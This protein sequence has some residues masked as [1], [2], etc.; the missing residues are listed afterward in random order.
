MHAHRGKASVASILSPGRR[1]KALVGGATAL[2]VVGALSLAAIVFAEPRFVAVCAA[3]TSEC[4]T[5]P[6]AADGSPSVEPTVAVLPLTTASGNRLRLVNENARG[7]TVLSIVG[8]FTGVS[9]DAEYD[10]YVAAPVDMDLTVTLNANE[11]KP[12]PLRGAPEQVRAVL[13]QLHGL[14]SAGDK[15]GARS[16]PS[17]EATT[18][19]SPEVD[20]GTA[21]PTADDAPAPSQEEEATTVVSVTTSR[22]D[23]STEELRDALT[24]HVQ[25]TPSPA[26]PS[27]APVASVVDTIVDDVAD[28]VANGSGNNGAAPAPAPS[29]TGTAAEE[30]PRP[31]PT[32]TSTAAP[33]PRPAVQ[34]P[35][36]EAEPAPAPA[37][38]PV[39]VPAPAPEPTES[40]P[41]NDA[42][43]VVQGNI[44][45]T[46]AGTVL[47]SVDLHGRVIV[48]AADVTIR[49]S[50][51]RGADGGERGA[52]VNAL[53]GAPRL[54][55]LDTEI[56]ATVPNYYVN[57]IM[58]FNFELRRVNIHSV[59][60]QVH[61]TGGNVTIDDSWLH[62]NLHY[63]PDPNHSD[64]KSHDDNVQIQAGS[65][66]RITN[67]ILSGSHNA[68]IMI[69]Q[70]SG[71]VSDVLVSGNR[72]ADGG[73]TVN[74][75]Q[76][77]RGPLSGITLKDNVFELTMQFRRCALVIDSDGTTPTLDNDKFTDG[78]SIGITR[79]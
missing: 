74:I 72:F 62:G 53:A 2:G 55:I 15:H 7:A 29:P 24:K 54:K 31:K 12:L 27:A 32:K 25:A 26:G 76:G 4:A 37:P 69:T 57:G 17:A 65:N 50:I 73:C 30:A 66:I 78:S 11:S 40:N 13:V 77:P 58:G 68:A 51:I 34:P 10:D 28:E 60:D 21:T 23:I 14:T 63:S 48:K 1:A 41:S 33:Q 49:N 38:P 20:A 79:H 36:P 43:K 45:I 35:S 19:A 67:S 22:Q 6:L 47:D 70:G 75:A 71:V 46:K 5:S 42:L 52:L 44:T 39:T 64:N 8:F 59:I 18:S 9:A 61:L 56:A 3:E 16:V